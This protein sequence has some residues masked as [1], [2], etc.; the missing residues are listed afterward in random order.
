MR[1]IKL[2]K[3]KLF[4]RI[5]I[6]IFIRQNGRLKNNNT[7]T[8]KSERKTEANSLTKQIKI[9]K[10]LPIQFMI[11][12]VKTSWYRTITDKEI[13]RYKG[14]WESLCNWLSHDSYFVQKVL[15]IRN[16]ITMRPKTKCQLN[17][18]LHSDFS[19][20]GHY[21][22]WGVDTGFV[23]KLWFKYSAVKV[24]KRLK[25]MDGWRFLSGCMS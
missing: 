11:F 3:W 18:Y 1:T 25:V 19:P 17:F 4:R 22:Y 16:Y 12:L 9:C 10:H 8:I 5:Y 13:R 20:E 7:K 14:S 15:T 6:F 23:R 2:M 21:C 24:S